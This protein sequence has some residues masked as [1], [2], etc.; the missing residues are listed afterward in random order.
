MFLGHLAQRKCKMF[1]GVAGE[2]WELMQLETLPSS[3]IPN[4]QLILHSS[5]MRQG[6]Y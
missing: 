6:G 5:V 4:L 2:R 1:K 3:V